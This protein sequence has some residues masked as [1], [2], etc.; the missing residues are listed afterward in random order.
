L[1]G[2]LLFGAQQ[3]AFSWRAKRHGGGRAV[4]LRQEA[5]G[6][7]V[8]DGLRRFAIPHVKRAHD[9][10]GGIAVRL[11]AV[12]QKYVGGTGYLPRRDDVILD[13]GAGLGEFTLWCCDAG[14]R[15]IAF[16]PDP[17]A[18]HC[19]E[20][21][22]TFCADVRAMPLALWKE[23]AELRLHGSPDTS[24]S[25]LIED[26]RRSVRLADAQAW[27]LDGVSAVS[28]LPV[29]DFMKV[30]GEGVEPEILAGGIRT[31]RRTRVLAVDVSAT[32]K[33]KDLAAR[34]QATLD[35]LNFRPVPHD[36][37]DTILALNTAM[38]GPFNSLGSGR[39][40]S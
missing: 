33:R 28:A 39:R 7:S 10:R 18:F 26:G 19:L 36:R 25:S 2:R 40:G 21:N 12:A 27:P 14:A 31:L 38:V 4:K 20:R 24:D 9:Y 32:D 17:L 15:V 11:E 34:V 23:R 1:Q 5:D 16:E 30:D 13:I 35:T 22:V 8:D 37:N 29:I 6:L 3:I